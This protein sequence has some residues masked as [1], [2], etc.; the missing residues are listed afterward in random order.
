MRGLER[1]IEE[2]RVMSNAVHSLILCDA[3]QIFFR[4]RDALDLSIWRAEG[5]EEN[6]RQKGRNPK[7]TCR[8]GSEGTRGQ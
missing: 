8:R 1:C 2:M 4:G 6:K 7:D 3:R 5:E